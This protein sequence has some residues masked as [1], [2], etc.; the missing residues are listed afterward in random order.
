MSLARHQV[1]QL[2]IQPVAQHV[3][4]D[5]E[6]VLVAAAADDADVA[7][8]GAGAAVRAAGHAHAERFVLQPQLLQLRF[9]SSMM[10]GNA[11]S[12]SERARPHVGIA[13]QAMLSFRTSERC[14]GRGMPC[15]SSIRSRAG[16][17]A[18]SRSHSRMSCSGVSRSSGR[19][20]S[21]MAR[22]AERRRSA[23][24]SLT[25][26]FSMLRPKNHLP[27]PCGCQPRC[28]SRPVTSTG[29]AARAF[30]EV[31]GQHLAEFLDA[32]VVDDV[33][34]AG[35][36]AVGPVAVVAEQ[37]DAPPRPRPPRRRRDI[38]DRLGQVRKRVGVAVRHA[39]AAADQHVVADDA[40]VLDDGQQ[41][42][43]LGV[44]VDAVVVRRRQAGFE[45]AR[46]IDLAVDRFD[47]RRSVASFPDTVLAVEPDFV[48]GAGARRQWAARRAAVA[49]SS[50]WTP[51]CR[52]GAGQ[53][54]TLRFTSPQA[55]SV[56]SRQSLMPA[57]VSLRLPL[58]TPWNWM[59]WRW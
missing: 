46:Q 17:S 28:R 50:S 37:L 36:L 49:C 6:D 48:V 52:C 15:S 7:L 32:P 33:F 12:A 34:D 16:R 18:P 57:M 23:P 10:P 19:N 30:A 39:H 56:V 35:P 11:R 5:K 31:A 8:V 3:A 25:R 20:R 53:A 9:Q 59:P 47:L 51:S 4:A 54:M 1:L 22:R 42:E 45:L 21:T 58:R 14:S 41:A 55:P 38:A 24:S 27:S 13:G 40:A 44:N 43:V 29:A 26:P 2:E